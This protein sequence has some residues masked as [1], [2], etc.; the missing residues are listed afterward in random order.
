[1]E[2]R[3]KTSGDYHREHDRLHGAHHSNCLFLRTPPVRE[4]SDT[5]TNEGSLITKI[6]FNESHQGYDGKVHGGLISAITDSVMVRCLMGH[7]ILSYTAELKMRY[8]LPV[9]INKE[10]IFVT[11]ILSSGRDRLYSL[12]TKIYQDNEIKI[13]G[14]SRFY[15]YNAKA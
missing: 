6:V 11:T 7:G 5:F 13:T 14:K 15:R 9:E 4:I 12:E 10:T 2:T 3:E 8:K 1:M